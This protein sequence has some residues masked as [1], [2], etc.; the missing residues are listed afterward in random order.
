VIDAAV[1]GMG[2][3]RALSYQVAEF[4][5]RG[6]LVVVLGGFERRKW[7][8]HL[9]YNGQSRLPLKLRAF[10]DFAAP[11]LRQRLADAEL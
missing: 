4:V 8:V 11:R 9:L 2:L 6:A 10:I 5:R 7:P 1:G 3:T